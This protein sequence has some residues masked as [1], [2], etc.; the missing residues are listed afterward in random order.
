MGTQAGNSPLTEFGKLIET[1]R[2]RLGMTQID[3]GKAVEIRRPGQRDVTAEA[4]QTYIAR[5][6]KG[7]VPDPQP[8]LLHAL[9]VALKLP[10]T[11]LIAKL[12]AQKY[13]LCDEFVSPMLRNP[14][15]LD[16]LADWEAKQTEL[17]IVTPDFLD[18]KRT[19]FRDA[20]VSCLKKPNGRVV[21]FLPKAKR[22]SFERYKGTL[23]R[24]GIRNIDTS[25]VIVP[26][27]DNQMALI[28]ACYVIANP[29]LQLRESQDDDPETEGYLIIYD[30]GAPYLAIQMSRQEIEERV[31]VLD[32]FLA[33]TT[34]ATAAG[35]RA[36]D[37]K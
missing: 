18:E 35:N 14:L 32:H 25:L 13:E 22:T 16:Q 12:V 2:K 7:M 27:D 29:S 15:T 3:L 34:D 6:E 5:L 31:P 24:Q 28:A 1:E 30:H 33:L 26:G 23:K 4:L 20:V 10:Y 21:F 9:S 11:T 8:A 36:T 17:W 19:K 37:P